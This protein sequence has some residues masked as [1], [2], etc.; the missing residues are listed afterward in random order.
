MAGIN[1]RAFEHLSITWDILKT[2]PLYN[3]PSYKII[4]RNNVILPLSP[5]NEGK[6]T[7]VIDLD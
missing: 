2:C 4:K 7:L 3:L 1:E 5:S 6:K